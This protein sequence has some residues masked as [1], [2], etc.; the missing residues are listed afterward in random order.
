MNVDAKLELFK[1]RHEQ[2]V[3]DVFISGRILDLSLIQNTKPVAIVYG[4]H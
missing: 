1:N 2:D 3:M 4:D